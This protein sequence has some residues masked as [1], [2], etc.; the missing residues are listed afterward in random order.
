MQSKDICGEC[1]VFKNTFRY[2]VSRKTMKSSGNSVQTSS[3]SDASTTGGNEKALDDSDVSDDDSS[4][5]H[6][7]LIG[8]A[9]KHV[10]KAKS[11]RSL[12]RETILHAQNDASKE[13]EERRCVPFRML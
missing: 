9:N 12:T 4:Y 2:A 11:M 5:L 6:E 1:L 10:E 7:E 8:E 3:D 13:H